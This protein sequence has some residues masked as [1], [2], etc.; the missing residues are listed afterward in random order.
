MTTSSQK[1]HLERGLFG[2][3]SRHQRS[4]EAY[5]FDIKIQK[6]NIPDEVRER[7]S[8]SRIGAI[9]EVEASGRLNAFMD[10]LKNDFPWIHEW[11]QDGRSGG[12]LVIEPDAAALDEYGNVEDV[13]F[14][15]KRLSDLDEIAARV[16]EAKKALKK[17]MGSS[18]W[19]GG[20]VKKVKKQDWS[21]R[22][23]KRK[24]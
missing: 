22:S 21:P 24:E 9:F 4:G 16:E 5:E 2:H 19:W 12:W 6:I 11:R 15:R 3:L 20:R 13:R 10:E 8:D 7:V 18:E 14:A 17:D 23:G 1:E